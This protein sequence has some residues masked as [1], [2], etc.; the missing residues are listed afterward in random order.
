[1]L[2]EHVH[3]YGR[4]D[5]HERVQAGLE[6]YSAV[7]AACSSGFSARGPRRGRRYY[8]LTLARHCGHSEWFLGGKKVGFTMMRSHTGDDVDSQTISLTHKRTSKK[9][10]FND[11]YSRRVHHVESIAHEERRGNIVCHSGLRKVDCGELADRDVTVCYGD[12]V[13]FTHLRRANGMES[14][15]GDSG[16]PVYRNLS[17]DRALA[18]GLVSGGPRFDFVGL[19]DYSYYSHAERIERYHDIEICTL[20]RKC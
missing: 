15:P 6:V 2:E 8:R 14:K 10:W 18:T 13:C 7:G 20:Q 5:Y 16:G 17:K 3:A 12:D 1:V 4:A 9:I 11:T 19:R